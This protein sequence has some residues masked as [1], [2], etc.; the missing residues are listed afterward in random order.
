[1]AIKDWPT[2]ERPQEKLLSSG[3]RTLSDA[4]LL[5]LFI[6]S[7][8]RGLTA[9]DIGRDLIDKFGGLRQILGASQKAICDTNGLGPA[10]YALLQAS[11]ELGRRYLDQTLR[12]QG[13]LS[14]PSQAAE[15]LT[16][17]LRDL[18][19]E[20]FAVIYLDTRHQVIDY[21]ELFTGTLNGATVHPREVV[22]S[23]LERNASAVILAHNHPSGI[24]EPS[25]SDAT[26]TQRLR[27]SLEL[28]DVRLLDHLVIGDGE[29]VSMSD[30]GL[31]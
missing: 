23:V 9:L 27:E 16:Y 17:Q 7:G 29:Y 6:R 2:R 4:E 13:P 30:R 1:M 20:V 10:K 28:I 18:K 24:A 12:K 26:L 5:A 19:R 8:S 11:L 15:F 31:F 14:S 21:E 3:A 22:K 25:Q